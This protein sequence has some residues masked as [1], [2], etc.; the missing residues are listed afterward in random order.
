MEREQ[1]YR[2]AVSHA[3]AGF[4]LIEE[5]LKDYLGFYHVAVRKLL[6]SAL[7]YK[8]SRKDI[9]D[10]ALGKLIN[11]FA[12]SSGNVRLISELRSL[13]NTRDQLA[14]KALLDL[15]GTADNQV[16]LEIRSAALHRAAVKISELLDLINKESLNVLTAA[17]LVK[18][19]D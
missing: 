8:S 9:Q 10:S 7:T 13:T 16:D 19:L 15:Y 12:K 11:V 1:Q 14:H 5:A 6:P 18:S 3:L 17:G 2:D 4:Q